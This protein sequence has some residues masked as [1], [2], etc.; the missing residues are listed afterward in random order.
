VAP[1][2]REGDLHGCHALVDTTELHR[3]D[4]GV[5]S[6]CQ[7]GLV[8]SVF[9]CR[10]PPLLVGSNCIALQEKVWARTFPGLGATLANGLQTQHGR[11]VCPSLQQW[12]YSWCRANTY[13]DIK[14][15]RDVESLQAPKERVEQNTVKWGRKLQVGVCMVL[16]RP[17]KG[18][19]V[20]ELSC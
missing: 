10:H 19:V 9:S 5:C 20:L 11:D 16:K 2:G 15:A 6:L 3:G 12:M 4:D 13:T 1:L 7:S 14:G 18:V 8:W 17:L